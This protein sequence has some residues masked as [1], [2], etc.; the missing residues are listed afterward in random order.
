MKLEVIGRTE[1][2]QEIHLIEFKGEVSESPILLLGGVHGNEYEGTMLVSSL[3]NSLKEHLPPLKKSIYIIPCLN[4]DGHLFD[5]RSNVNDVDLNRNIPSK[6]WKAEYTNPRYKPGPSPASE[7][8]T[9]CFMA[10]LEKIKPGFIISCHSFTKSLLLY[11]NIDRFYDKS[12]ENFA[13]ELGI[14][15][16]DKMDYEITGSLN[17]LS[18]D[19]NIPVLTVE[20]PRGIEW[21]QRKDEFCSKFIEFV[22][23]LIEN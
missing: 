11:S 7:S 19:L 15:L 13:Q 5:I 17:S 4:K 18:R 10:V 21:A 8:E 1:L 2:G 3:L 20:C 23:K 9:K 22:N 6:N 14:P 12:V 16:V